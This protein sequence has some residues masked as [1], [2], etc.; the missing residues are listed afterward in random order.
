M[1]FTGLIHCD[2]KPMWEIEW[3]KDEGVD[4]NSVSRY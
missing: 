2:A 1:D 4:L 3:H